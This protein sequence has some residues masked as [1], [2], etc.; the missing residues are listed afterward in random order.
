MRSI[1]VPVNFTENSN[2]AARYAADMALAIDGD[3]HL[4]YVFQLPL[5]IAEFPIPDATIEE[6]QRDSR[7]TLNALKDELRQ[8]TRDQVGVTT[9]MTAEWFR[10]ARQIAPLAA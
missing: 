10:R 6:M 4:I 1:V 8:R 7:I 9:E 2:N 3:I 5:T